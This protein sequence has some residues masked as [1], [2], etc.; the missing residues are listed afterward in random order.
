MHVCRCKDPEARKQWNA[1]VKELEKWMDEQDTDPL[2]T[3][4]VLAMLRSWV[5]EHDAPVQPS[6]IARC[7]CSL[8][9]A[10]LAQSTIG[11]WNTL[12]GRISKQLTQQ[13]Q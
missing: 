13:Q 4:H 8:R 6:A 5:Q 2:I 3:K 9:K 1:S 11:P 12:L 7:N 10:L